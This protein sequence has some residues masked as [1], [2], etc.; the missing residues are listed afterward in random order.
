MN[1]DGI[2]ELALT[3]RGEPHLGDVVLLYQQTLPGALATVDAD[4]EIQTDGTLVAR[5]TQLGHA[6][7]NGDGYDDLLLGNPNDDSGAG[8]VLIFSGM[9][10]GGTGLEPDAE[11]IGRDGSYTG[12]AIASPGDLDGDGKDELLIGAPGDGGLY[13][14]QD[15]ESGR[16]ALDDAAQASFWRAEDA[17]DAGAALGAGNLTSDVGGQ[18]VIGVPQAGDENQGAV[19]LMPTLDL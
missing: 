3:A 15:G 19:V 4:V 16:F 13:L 1:G 5:W 14:H 9:L 10:D 6:D 8:S 12:K 2:D 18:F 7:L 17:S 11:L